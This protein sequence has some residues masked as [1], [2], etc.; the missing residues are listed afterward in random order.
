VSDVFSAGIF[1][2]CSHL[3]T[4]LQKIFFLKSIAYNVGT[5][6]QTFEVPIEYRNIPPN[7]ALD[8]TVPNKAKVTVSGP[9]RAYQFLEPTNLKISI[10]LGVS[11][12][13]SQVLPITEKNLKLPTSL[14]IRRI[15]PQVLWITLRRTAS[16]MPLNL[17]IPE[18][19]RHRLYPVLSAHVQARDSE[20]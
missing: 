18:I 8:E 11:S 2:M 6:Q 13:G 19:E 10:D 3:S 7:L 14:S 4:H 5:I 17:A 9:E 16:T 1:P 20:T 12:I 15:E